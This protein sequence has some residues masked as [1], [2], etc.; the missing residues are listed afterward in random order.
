MHVTKTIAIDIETVPLQNHMEWWAKSEVKAPSNYKDETKIKEYI[1][2]AKSE[3]GNKSALT[4]HTGKVA[5][6]SIVDIYTM[7]VSHYASVNEI[8]LLDK[9]GL[10]T[11]VLHLH[12]VSRQKSLTSLSWLEDF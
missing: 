4:W 2:K 3:L 8:E 7:A 9:I 11:R 1:D 10:L 12:G 5:S 6:F